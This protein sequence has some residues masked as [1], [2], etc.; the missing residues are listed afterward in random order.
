MESGSV[1]WGA[2]A[3][4]SWGFADFIAR[5][6]GRS[7]GVAATFHAV[8]VIGLGALLLFMWL[9]GETM[10][11]HN[12]DAAG[13][14]GLGLLVLSG[15]SAAIATIFLYEALTKGPVSLSS[16]VVSSYP[17]LAMPISIAFGANPNWWHW[18]AM[19]LTLG[20]IWLVALVVSSESKWREHYDGSVIRRS[21]LLSIG[22]ALGFAITLIAADRAIEIYGPWQTM[23]VTRIVGAIIFISWFMLRR[24]LPRLYPRL[25]PILIALSLLDTMGYL[26]VY[27]GLGH[28][29]GEFAIIA[30]SAYS[31]VAVILARIFLR[32]PVNMVQWGGVALVVGGIALLSL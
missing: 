15:V 26:G 6:T 14:L 24:E 19:I 12:P 28:A 4:I 21:I 22:G 8:S 30:S 3:A 10:L 9:R 25:W 5:F 29:N 23:V 17:A 16:P 7:V 2:G 18:L 11:W 27:I 1:L 20:G 31:V 32:E 13:L